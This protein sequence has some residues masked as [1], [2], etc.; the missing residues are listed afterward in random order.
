MS[1]LLVPEEEQQRMVMEG[2]EELLVLTLFCILESL[3]VHIIGSRR[4][5]R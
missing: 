4:V 1:V 3:N 2:S 5:I